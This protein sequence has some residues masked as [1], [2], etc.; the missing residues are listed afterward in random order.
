M[1]KGKSKAKVEPRLTLI[2]RQGNSMIAE[3]MMIDAVE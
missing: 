1:R 2:D 3:R